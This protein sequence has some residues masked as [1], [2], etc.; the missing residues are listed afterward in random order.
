MV[1]YIEAHISD[2]N[3]D[4]RVLSKELA[5]SRSILYTKVKS[6][7]GQT[8]HEF[9]KSIRLKRSLRLLLEGDVSISQVAIEVG[10]NSHSYF[11]KCFVKQYKMGPKEYVNRKRGK[12]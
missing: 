1:Q 8:V 6:L 5:T 7:T 12:G 11:D 10:F 9:I 2:T 4:A 3:L